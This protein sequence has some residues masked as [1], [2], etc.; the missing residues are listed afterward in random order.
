MEAGFPKVTVGFSYHAGNDM[1][2]CPR[3]I[4]ATDTKKY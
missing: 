1:K 4:I 3:L 2:I